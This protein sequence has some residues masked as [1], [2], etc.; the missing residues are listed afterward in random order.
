MKIRDFT[1]SFVI[2]T[3]IIAGCGGNGSSNGNSPAPANNGS[4]STS[5]SLGNPNPV[6]SATPVESVTPSPIFTPTPLPTATPFTPP[7][8]PST[9]IDNRPQVFKDLESY[10]ITVSVEQNP[11]PGARP[12]AE[13]L[14]EFLPELTNREGLLY[15]HRDEIHSLVLST[16]TDYNED[17]KQLTLGVDL[18]DR[19]FVRFFNY[20]DRERA[21]ENYANLQ[22]DLGI[23]DY[24]LGNSDQLGAYA[25]NIAYL[26][27]HQ[28]LLRTSSGF[29]K[30]ISMGELTFYSLTDH[31]LQVDRNHFQDA[32]TAFLTTYSFAGSFFQFAESFHLE[33]H[34]NFNLNDSKNLD[35]FKTLM[36]QLAAA[37]PSLQT[38]A[39]LDRL[40]VINISADQLYPSFDAR[41]KQLGVATV[42]NIATNTDV[43]NA[44]AYQFTQEKEFGFEFQ[45]TFSQLGTN[46]LKVIQ[47][48]K[49]FETTIVAK[50]RTIL[51]IQLAET[52]G[53]RGETLTIGYGDTDAQFAA[54]LQKIN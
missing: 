14:Q 44:L 26:E 15:I 36:N 6:A 49:Q 3:A 21:V 45:N 7:F 19:D 18:S 43:I 53:Y 31:S 37:E 47:R 52:S 10:G 5:N 48:L 51:M 35:D 27:T 17:G 4:G 40:A 38:M 34:G 33:V 29:V 25:S 13:R 24:G 2:S 11:T 22:I 46:Y 1:V 50:K 20:F 32:L 8:P 30:S 12:F 28:D 54:L 39:R 42:T 23:A 16:Y 9:P 41:T